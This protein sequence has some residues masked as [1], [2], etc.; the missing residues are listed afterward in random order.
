[1]ISRGR[2][3]CCPE[4]QNHRTEISGRSS[5]TTT[6]VILRWPETGKVERPSIRRISL[7]LYSPITSNVGPGPSETKGT[8]TV[9]PSMHSVAARAAEREMICR[10]RLTVAEYLMTRESSDFIGGFGPTHSPISK[11]QSARSRI[12]RTSPIE[13]LSQLLG[14]STRTPE[15]DSV[16]LNLL[17]QRQAHHLSR[18][19]T[20]RNPSPR[21]CAPNTLIVGPDPTHASTLT[22]TVTVTSMAV[23]RVVRSDESIVNRLVRAPAR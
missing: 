21:P 15:C 23:R 12:G 18:G 2:T 10:R 13:A 4:I 6:V 8:G 11:S 5:D 3:R 14:R 17:L 1:M 16:D 19:L 7:S 20:P 9:M 22:V